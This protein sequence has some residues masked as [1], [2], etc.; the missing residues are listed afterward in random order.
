MPRRNAGDLYEIA[1]GD[2]TCMYMQHIG[3]DETLPGSAVVRVFRSRYARQSPL[4]AQV[5]CSD[6]VAFHS[7]VF[8]KAGETLSVWRKCGIGPLPAKSPRVHWCTPG[9]DKLR[10]AECSDWALWQTNEPKTDV[11][12]SDSRLSTAEVGMVMSPLLI[13][14]RAESGAWSFPWPRRA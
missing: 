2:D 11:K 8:L 13:K 9:I 12:S 3:S 5:I 6:E 14:E 4:H 7:H 1:I 10:L